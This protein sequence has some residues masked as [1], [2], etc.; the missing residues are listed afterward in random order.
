MGAQTR[1]PFV[2]LDLVTIMLIL[3]AENEIAAKQFLRW[4][5]ISTDR[6]DDC[7]AVTDYPKLLL[8]KSTQLVPG[9]KE[10]LTRIF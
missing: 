8:L 10:W 4:L 3:R 5:T 7:P 6:P 1:L 2:L 9:S